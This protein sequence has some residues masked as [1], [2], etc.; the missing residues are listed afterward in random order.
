MNDNPVSRN[1]VRRLIASHEE[2]EPL[3]DTKEVTVK[4]K[5]YRTTRKGWRPTALP[6]SE[7]A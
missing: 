2:I 7:E 3:R 1:L 6:R 4:L 5:I